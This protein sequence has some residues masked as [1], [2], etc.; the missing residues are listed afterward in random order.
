[1]AAGD[2]LKV[3]RRRWFFPYYYHGIDTGNDSVIHFARA[4]NE[5]GTVIESSLEEFLKGGVKEFEDYSPLIDWLIRD[6]H[7]DP[8]TNRQILER[9]DDPEAAVA[10]AR[11]HLGKRGYGTYLDRGHWPRFASEGFARVGEGF[12]VYCKTGF[13]TLGIGALL[14][15]LQ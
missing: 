12:A 14:L 15:P 5:P 10:E 7:R 13:F 2:H 1:M 9:I 11:N 4:R 3:K 8:T 6:L